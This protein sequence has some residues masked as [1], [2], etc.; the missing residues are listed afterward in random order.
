MS[1]GEYV[2]KQGMSRKAIR[3]LVAI[4]RDAFDL[5]EE[6]YFPVTKFLE[7]VL[8]NIEEGFEYEVKTMEEM[9]SRYAVTYPEEKRI[10]IREDVYDRAVDGNPRDRFTIAHEIGHYLMH[11]PSTVSF[12]RDNGER[13]PPYLDPEWQANTFAGELLAPPALIK[14]MSVECVMEECGVSRKVAGIQLNS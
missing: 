6:R 14:G 12:A 10:D 11:S 4:V 2:C 7:L 9:G 5:T 1:S 13:T 8:P 3:E